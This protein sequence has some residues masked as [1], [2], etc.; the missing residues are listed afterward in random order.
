VQLAKLVLPGMLKRKR[1]V[2]V[3]VGSGNGLLPA[4]PLLATYAGT[5]SF[6]NQFS[7]SLDA[8]TRP[9]GV[10]VQ[11]QPPLYVATKMSKIRRARLDAPTPEV[12]ARAAARQIGYGTSLTPY[13]YHGLMLSLLEALAPAF[14]INRRVRAMHVA[15]RAA[16]LRRKA[17]EQ[18]AAAAAAL[19]TAAEP[20]KR[21]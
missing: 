14:V 21:K 10:R 9:M 13:W 11:D 5:K 4:V 18:A 16:A 7:R 6:I 19:A 1:G 3:N 8:E 12:W 2:I 17:R 20:K 15:F